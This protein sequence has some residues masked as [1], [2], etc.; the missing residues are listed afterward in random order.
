[1]GI[2]GK[3]VVTAQVM[4]IVSSTMFVGHGQVTAP[5]PTS[6]ADASVS[7]VS[8]VTLITNQPPTPLQQLANGLE[9][10]KNLASQFGSKGPAIV[11]AITDNP[12]AFLTNLLDGLSA[13]ALNWSRI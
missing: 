4:S 12:G 8:A 6:F 11:Q 2:T 7:A 1:M 3:I 5:F 9:L 10:V 13:A